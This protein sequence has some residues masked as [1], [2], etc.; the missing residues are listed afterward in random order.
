MDA[1]LAFLNVW[2]NGRRHMPLKDERPWTPKPSETWFLPAERS[3]GD[4]VRPGEVTV[5]DG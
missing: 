1:G 5:V 3:E 2:A 4:E